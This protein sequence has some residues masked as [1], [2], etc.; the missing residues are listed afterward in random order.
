[1]DPDRIT[2]KAK[3]TLGKAEAGLGDA[4]G[5][6]ETEA[7]GRVRQAKG[8]AENLYG[9]AKDAI[10]DVVGDNFQDVGKSAEDMLHTIERQVKDRPL[11]ALLIAALIGFVLAQLTSS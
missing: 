3:E 4:I 2:G 11:I 10:D 5:D 6:N 7:R 9:Q 1:M 8:A